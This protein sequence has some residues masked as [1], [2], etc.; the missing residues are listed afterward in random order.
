MSVAVNNINTR[1]HNTIIAYRYLLLCMYIDTIKSAIVTNY[2]LTSI[3][4]T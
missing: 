1:S 3:T 4:V 2:Y